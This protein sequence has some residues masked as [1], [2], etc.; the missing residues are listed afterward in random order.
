MRFTTWSTGTLTNV[1]F[2]SAVALLSQIIVANADSNGNVLEF[3]DPG[4]DSPL[5]FAEEMYTVKWYVPR[6]EAER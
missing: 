2:F 1:F 4:P 3:S 6:G 5:V